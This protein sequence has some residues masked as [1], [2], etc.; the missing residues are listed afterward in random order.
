MHKLFIYFQKCFESILSYV[1]GF[2]KKCISRA[3]T[4]LKGLTTEAMS[5]IGLTTG[6]MSLIGFITGGISIALLGMGVCGFCLGLIAYVLVLH[7]RVRV[8]GGGEL[9]EEVM[10]LSHFQQ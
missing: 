7:L 1:T 8:N 4:A 5:L 9:G 3:I 2:F 6:A 10:A